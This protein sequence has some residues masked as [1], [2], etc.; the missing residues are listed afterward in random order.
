MKLQT[1]DLRLLRSVLECGHRLEQTWTVVQ[2]PLPSLVKQLGELKELISSLAHAESEALSRLSFHARDL[3]P[4]MSAHHLAAILVPFERLLGRS[5]RDDEI[6]VIEGDRTFPNADT[7]TE[8]METAPIIAVAENLRSAFNVGAILRTSEALG[9]ERVILTGYTPTPA[10]DKAARTSMGTDKLISWESVAKTSEAIADLKARGYSIVAIETAAAATDLVDFVWPER[11]ALLVGNE[12]FGLDYETLNS[13][14]HVLRIP[15]YG[16]KNSLNVGIAFGI[17][18]NAGR[19]DFAA[20]CKKATPP[21]KADLI[22][23]PI[24]IFHGP[25]HRRY[26]A[27]RQGAVDESAEIATIELDAGRD[28]E[29]A[30]RDLSGFSHLWVIYHMHQIENWKPMIVPPRGPRTKR[31]L[32]ATRSPHRPNS[33]GLSAVELVQIDGRCLKVRGFDLLDGTPILDLKPYLP[34][35]D[36]FPQALTGWTSTLDAEKFAVCLTA[37]CLKQLNWLE[38]NGITPIRHFIT[39]QLEFDPTDSERKRVTSDVTPG[40]F[41]LAYQT[42]RIDFELPAAETSEVRV[43]NIRSGYSECD[44][45]DGADPYIDKTLHRAFNHLFATDS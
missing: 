6:E 8:P 32:F 4:E 2:P 33:I 22:Y 7:T 5:L 18:A 14:D 17:A 10:D 19:A 24:G 44:L 25:G 26:Q 41:T 15:L 16:R 38:A 23:R 34:Y 21:P 29:Q 27:R 28:F 9:L 42:W 13:A 39:S 31:G 35:A 30:L 37:T 43:L 36:S 11:C 20:R 1:G 45:L 40:R 12:R 3:K